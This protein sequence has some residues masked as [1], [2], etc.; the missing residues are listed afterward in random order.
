M[1]AQSIAYAALTPV[2]GLTQELQQEAA[3]LVRLAVPPYYQS[4]S[5]E[6][7]EELIAAE[8]ATP[9]TELEHCLA[10]VDGGRVLGILC[11]YPMQDMAERQYNSFQFVGRTLERADFAAFAANLR[12]LRS[13]FP[14]IDGE[15]EYLAFISV[16]EDVRGSGL[17]N[18]LLDRAISHAAL[19]P[20]FLTVRRDNERARAFYCK[21]GFEQVAAGTDYAFLSRAPGAVHE[22]S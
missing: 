17:A 22:P 13:D 2:Q 15:G 14:E 19:D 3:R 11:T 4:L 6:A 9:G 18:V 16:A 8:F 7:A 10:A 5:F 1:T 21:H 12:L 20:L